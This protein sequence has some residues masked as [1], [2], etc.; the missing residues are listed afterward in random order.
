MFELERG[1]QIKGSRGE[2]TG[3]ARSFRE[4]GFTEIA[5]LFKMQEGR[6]RLFS[7]H[8]HWN[9]S[10]SG[11]SAWLQRHSARWA[12]LIRLNW[13]FELSFSWPWNWRHSQITPAKTLT[14]SVA[15]NHKHQLTVTDTKTRSTQWKIEPLT[16]VLLILSIYTPSSYSGSAER[17]EKC[18]HRPET[19]HDVL[20]CHI[21]L[22]KARQTSKL[23]TNERK[24][25]PSQ[26]LWLT[27]HIHWFV[28]EWDI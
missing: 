27:V 8:S 13:L 9:Q 11:F 22:Q 25:T 12:F 28:A 18:A 17:G 24:V 15:K 19:L 4:T 5:Q 20:K 21:R 16:H 2:M 1:Q 14:L 23:H 7:L 26:R 6:V 3:I 10:A